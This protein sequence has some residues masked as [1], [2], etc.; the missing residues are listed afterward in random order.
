MLHR[1]SHLAPVLLLLTGFG[2]SESTPKLDFDRVD[3]RKM[4]IDPYSYWSQPYSYYY[5]HHMD[6][7]PNQRLDWVRKPGQV[8]RLKEP[9]APFALTYTPNDKIYSLD[10][11]L[12][13]G[14]VIGL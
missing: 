10:D 4:L 6:K 5:F 3:P 8:F 12:H 11:F 9:T 14:D 7:I 1:L 13:Q 2:H